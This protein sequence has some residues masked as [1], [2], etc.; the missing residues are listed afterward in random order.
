MLFNLLSN[1]ILLIPVLFAIIIAFTVH[2]FSH[3]L[4]AELLGDETPKHLGRLTLNPMAHVHWLGLLLLVTAGF[5][6]GKPVPFNPN[7]LKN[8]K[9]GSVII[10][11]AGPLSNLIF[12]LIAVGAIYAINSTVGL[13]PDSLLAV[14]LIFLYQFNMVLMIFNLIPIPPLDGSKLL[15]ALIPDKYSAFKNN[16]A[17]NGPIILITLVIFDSFS[18]VSV[19]GK[20]F[21]FILGGANRIFF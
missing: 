12:A 3:A 14:F 17:I 5:G 10:G 20:L 18:S 4:A 7:R 21:T 2:E 6:W 16:L 11:L 1:P 13:L 9:W 8:A 19:F 15:F